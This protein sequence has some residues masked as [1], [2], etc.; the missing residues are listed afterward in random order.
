MTRSCALLRDGVAQDGHFL[1]PLMPFGAYQHLS[2]EDARA[3]VAYLRT[4]PPYR[5]AQAAPG[6]QARVHARS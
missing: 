4:V 1:M 3:V 2:D 5:Q 6:E